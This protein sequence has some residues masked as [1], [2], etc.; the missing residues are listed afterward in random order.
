MVA[1]MVF[2]LLA[3]ALLHA[4]RQVARV[5]VFGA[6]NSLAF[7]ASAGVIGMASTFGYLDHV[8]GGVTLLA[9]M[10]VSRGRWALASML[11]TLGLA[12]HELFLLYGLPVVGLAMCLRRRSSSAALGG[13]LPMLV[14]LLPPFAFLMFVYYAQTTVSSE[15]VALLRAEMLST[16][17]LDEPAVGSVLYQLETSFG[18]NFAQHA[19][20]FSEHLLDWKIGRISWPTLASLIATSVAILWGAGRARLAPL[21]VV[22]SLAPLG[23][24]ALGQDAS[25]FTYL[26]VVQA[27]FCVYTVATGVQAPVPS[28]ALPR[29]ARVVLTLSALLAIAASLYWRAPLMG[30]LIDGKGMYAPRAQPLALPGPR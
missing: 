10:A 20:R 17:T 6:L 9:V 15:R 22:V 7:L 14:A 23:I 8:L 4:A 27:F 1:S 16:R 2:L 13:W 18:G 25:R 28:G 24:H 5:G 11:C 21:A 30:R 19:R 26:S 29:T 12:V 3:C